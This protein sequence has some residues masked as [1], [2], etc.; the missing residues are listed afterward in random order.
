MNPVFCECGERIETL[1]AEACRRCGPAKRGGRPP[2]ERAG[3]PIGSRS[4]LAELPDRPAWMEAAAC[5]GLDPDLF[6]PEQG[7]STLEA[8]EVCAGCPVAE[9][10]RDHAI[11]TG[12]KQ[13]IWGGTTGRQRRRLTVGTRGRDRNPETLARVRHAKALRREGLTYAEIADKLGVTRAAVGR[14]L[15]ERDDVAS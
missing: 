5:R 14:W 2:A 6:F 10:C 12:E 9:E 7:H 3:R 4:A 11:A 1:Y 8:M 13:G 15:A